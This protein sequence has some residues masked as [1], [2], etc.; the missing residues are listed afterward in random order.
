MIHI[1]IFILIRIWV[2][3][4]TEVGGNTMVRTYRP[5]LLK[6]RLTYV[7]AMLLKVTLHLSAPLHRPAAGYSLFSCA[8]F[9][10]Q[11]KVI[12]LR[13]ICEYPIPKNY[14]KGNLRSKLH[15]VHVCRIIK[16]LTG[17]MIKPLL[18]WVRSSCACNTFIFNH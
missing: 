9:P 18:R 4:G 2:V 6:L 5:Q 8:F 13:N 16:W 1:T 15:C 12:Y 3:H 10:R 7:P 11:C 17:N 14:I